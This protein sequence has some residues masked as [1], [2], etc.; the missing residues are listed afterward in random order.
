MCGPL[1]RVLIAGLVL[2]AVAAVWLK[3]ASA[4][5]DREKEIAAFNK[6]Y[7]EVLVRSLPQTLGRHCRTNCSRELATIPG[8]ASGVA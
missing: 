8:G 3:A 2:L 4:N 7:V 1:K 6:D 5:M